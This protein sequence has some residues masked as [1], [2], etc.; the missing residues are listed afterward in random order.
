[1]INN[2]QKGFLAAGALYAC[3]AAIAATILI[4]NRHEST[5]GQSREIRIACCCDKQDS[6]QPIQNQQKSIEKKQENSPKQQK[7]VLNTQKQ[8]SKLS[9]L[10]QTQTSNQT[11]NAT[12]IIAPTQKL[13]NTAA[14]KKQYNELNA[15][16]IAAALA[17][18]ANNY[19]FEK[20]IKNGMGEGICKI[21]FTLH[22]DGTV[23]DKKADDCSMWLRKSAL[24]A[25]DEAV[26]ELPKPNEDCK[27]NTSIDYEI[28]RR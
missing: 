9:S 20:A 11:Q 6:T 15:Q 2:F 16:K 21:G 26:I 17:R 8:P 24:A 5:I 12:P 14:P 22:P 3:S 25:I 27:I 23:S 4:S 13:E 28:V 1:M 10:P 18:H 7:N 19:Y